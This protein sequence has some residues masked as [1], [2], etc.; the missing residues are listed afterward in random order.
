MV[1]IWS[2]PILRKAHVSSRSAVRAGGLE[3]ASSE[4]LFGAIVDDDGNESKEIESTGSAR[5]ATI[6]WPNNENFYKSEGE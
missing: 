1:I 5:T 6:I 4:V 3:R 2:T